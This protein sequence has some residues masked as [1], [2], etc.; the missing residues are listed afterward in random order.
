VLLRAAIVNA[1]SFMVYEKAQQ[2]VRKLNDVYYSM[3]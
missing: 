3:Y 1:C 2:Q